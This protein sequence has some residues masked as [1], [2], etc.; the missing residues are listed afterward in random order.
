MLEKPKKYESL[1][2]QFYFDGEYEDKDVRRIT[3]KVHTFTKNSGYENV[4]SVFIERHEIQYVITFDVTD[5]GWST[6]FTELD[7]PLS[8]LIDSHKE[9]ATAQWSYANTYSGQLAISGYASPRYHNVLEKAM[10]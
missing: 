4:T 1:R 2:I 6:I 8:R 3:S 10:A 7:R 5:C 9:A